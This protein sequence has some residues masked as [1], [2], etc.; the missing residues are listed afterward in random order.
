MLIAAKMPF[1]SKI[2]KNCKE[3]GVNAAH[4][5]LGNPEIIHQDYESSYKNEWV[6]IAREMKRNRIYLIVHA[7][8]WYNFVKEGELQERTMNDAALQISVAGRLG[9]VAFI[10]SAGLAEEYDV[11][12]KKDAMS[13]LHDNLK[14]LLYNKADHTRLCIANS[15]IHKNALTVE[16]L[17]KVIQSGFSRSN[18]LFINFN[19]S[20]ALSCGYDMKQD[21]FK[22]IM[23]RVFCLDMTTFPNDGEVG[24]Y[25]RQWL[26][27]PLKG[28]VKLESAFE[29]LKKHQ[30][31]GFVVIDDTDKKNM[32]DNVSFIRS[33]HK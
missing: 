4:V 2:V 16:D 20:N 5:Y 14:H 24:N 10:F 17:L 7:P 21:S 32:K 31:N 6:E 29:Y 28:Q 30:F 15:G 26:N 9:A 25:R 13:N 8:H 19:T 27:E 33:L 23:R 1:D 18:S 12:H 22:E 3:L 11:I